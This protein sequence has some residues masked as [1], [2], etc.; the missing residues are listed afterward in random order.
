MAKKKYIFVV[1]GVM[2][3]VGKGIV[4][5]SV[6]KILQSK[7]LKVTA[8]KV[9]PYVNVDAG[10]MNPTEH[11]EVFVLDDG[12]EC[13]Q[14]LG[15]YERFLDKDFSQ[16]NSLTTGKVYLSVINKERALGY[17]GKC[18]EVVPHI[19][20]QIIEDL[21]TAAKKDKADIVLV[22]V[23]GTAGEYQNI[24]FLEAIR[25]LKLKHPKDVVT[26][27]VSYLPLRNRDNELKTKP[28]QYAVRTLNSTGIQPDIILGRASVP[29]DQ[30]RRG[31]IALNCNLD[32]EDVISAPE[33]DDVYEV[34]LVLEKAGI[35][36]RI[37][38]KLSL[39]NR[40]HDLKEWEKFVSKIK[41]TD[42]K[43][44]IGIVG[45]YFGTGNFV[46]SDAYLSVI[47]SIKHAA[48]SLG[49]KPQIDWI[50]ASGKASL[51]K[52]DGIIVPG[53]F[54]AR[55]VEGKIK[56]I[57]YAREKK[58]PFLGLCY[59]MQLAT[60]EFARN[61]AGLKGANSTE[62]NKKTPHPVIDV[63]PEQV[64]KLKNANYGG[65]MRLGAY[66]ALL[67]RG[68]IAKAAYKSEE[69]SERHRHRYEV[70]PEYIERLEASGLI[71]SGRSPSGLLMEIAEL[72]RSEHPFFLGTQFHPELKSRPLSPHPLFR[73]FIKTA[74]A[75]KGR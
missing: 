5:A 13:D 37:L 22:E 1:G 66:P 74:V 44:K 3:G 30:K 29:L 4:T 39:K 35:S 70:N 63:I 31:K 38:Q 52:Y 53:G 21:N 15:N 48:Y 32:I 40:K 26:I 72:P 64:E 43:V 55:D 11:G 58:V 65:T 45:K 61:V 7:G 62:I 50:N 33:V 9:D 69:I 36:K 51:S 59:G 19:P 46:L 17:G 73:E 34:P 12:S 25:L 27:L 47:E 49:Y 10:T 23:G 24:L 60:I 56:A 42:K 57:R 75:N 67:K 41:R 71:F 2:S 68:T 18:V 54:G 16:V 28:T 14:D 20:L 8:V 6:G